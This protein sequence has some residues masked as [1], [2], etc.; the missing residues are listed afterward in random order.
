MKF[1]RKA[2]FLSASMQ[3]QSWVLVQQGL[4]HGPL[5]H[6]WLLPFS[7]FP[8][9]T[10]LA[11][12][13]SLKAE[14]GGRWINERSVVTNDSQ[15]MYCL[16]QEPVTITFDIYG[17]MLM[18]SV[19]NQSLIIPAWGSSSSLGDKDRRQ[20]LFRKMCSLAAQTTIKTFP[21]RRMYGF[22]FYCLPLLPQ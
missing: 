11:L 8:L 19:T 15:Y 9:S 6:S 7:N 22:F 16:G 1:S 4:Q 20:A 21:R 5:F 12:M 14:Q 2:V 17:R 18:S 13:K 3:I 10:L